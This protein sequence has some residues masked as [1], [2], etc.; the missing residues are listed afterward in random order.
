MYS[1]TISKIK[2]TLENTR[3]AILWNMCGH[4]WVYLSQSY[5]E[6][7]QLAS[8]PLPLPPRTQQSW[9]SAKPSRLHYLH[10]WYMDWNRCL[11]RVFCLIHWQSWGPYR[12]WRIKTWFSFLCLS[13][14]WIKGHQ[15][16]SEF[17]EPIL[18]INIK[19]W[20]QSLIHEFKANIL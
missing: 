12:C 18:I 20:A 4:R 3:D 1:W 10:M 7:Q 17:S 9:Q 5:T 13:S 11:P 14:S 19:N 2:S 15:I 8:P 16:T 6:G